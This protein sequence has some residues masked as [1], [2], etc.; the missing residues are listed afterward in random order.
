MDNYVKRAISVVTRAKAIQKEGISVGL[1]NLGINKK[2]T[3]DPNSCY[4]FKGDSHH[5]FTDGEVK[6]R[7]ENG[8]LTATV[9]NASWAAVPNASG[10]HVTLYTQL[11]NMNADSAIHGWLRKREA[12]DS[13]SIKRLGF[14]YFA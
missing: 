4:T 6:Y 7:P 14:P 9:E 5:I 12:E 8:C 3:Q 10:K 1:A 2:Y 13:V 11:D